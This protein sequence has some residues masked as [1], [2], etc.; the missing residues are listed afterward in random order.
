MKFIKGR[1]SR[2]LQGNGKHQGAIRHTF[3][4][5]PTVKLTE[6]SLQDVLPA[7]VLRLSECS[8][9]G[10]QVQS[11]SFAGKEMHVRRARCGQGCWL[12]CLSIPGAPDPGLSAPR[13]VPDEIAAFAGPLSDREPGHR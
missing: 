1:S 5:T 9:P 2:V 11:H 10:N 7:S 8:M 6:W 13:Q 12:S 4:P 3:A